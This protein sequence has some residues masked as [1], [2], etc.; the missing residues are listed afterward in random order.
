MK[1]E[2]L[3]HEIL[4]LR[5]G[6][7]GR[8]LM[9]TACGLTVLGIWLSARGTAWGFAVSVLG[10]LVFAAVWLGGGETTVTRAAVSRRLRPLPRA[11]RIPI[12]DV[13][14]VDWT[15]GDFQ[16]S[17]FG[18]WEGSRG[19]LMGAVAESVE[20]PR[21]VGNRAVRLQLQS[22]KVVQFATWK[23]KTAIAAI[24][25]ALESAPPAQ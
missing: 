8:S 12:A 13:R 3:F 10:V 18:G 9:T 17:M 7:A 20:G 16:T 19:G 2:V 4:L 11:R 24:R 1:E 5:R 14:S 21:Q 23:P 22:G 15:I 6:P 25:S